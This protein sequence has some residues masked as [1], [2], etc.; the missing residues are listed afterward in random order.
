MAKKMTGKIT[1]RKIRF[2]RKNKGRLKYWRHFRRSVGV[3]W[4]LSILL[5]GAI[6]CVI[7]SLFYVS[8]HAPEW[9]LREL[10]IQDRIDLSGP[11]LSN[12]GNIVLKAE[13]E[14]AFEK[15]GPVGDFFGG[16]INPVLTF[17]SV[18]LL[19]LSIKTQREEL[20]ETRKEMQAATLQAER[21][22]TAAKESIKVTK[23]NE[24]PL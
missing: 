24:R 13:R 11:S 5:I 6:C 4:P 2:I 19:L 9:T 12:Q 23:I 15:L 20:K 3:F 1:A 18:C 16:I 7:V 10:G 17:I 14:S 8:V 21:T 22:A